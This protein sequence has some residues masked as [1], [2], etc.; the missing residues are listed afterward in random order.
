MVY[1][2][3]YITGKYNTPYTLNNQGFSIA[4][5]EVSSHII[6]QQTHHHQLFN[7]PNGKKNVSQFHKTTWSCQ[8]T[9]RKAWMQS[10]KQ[11]RHPRFPKKVPAPD[12][13]FPTQICSCCLFFC[14]QNHRVHRN[15]ECWHVMMLTS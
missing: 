8:T 5:M 3:A 4:H 15:L 7:L 14:L 12:L 13:V 1:C 9:P 10:A 2:N 11:P 6:L